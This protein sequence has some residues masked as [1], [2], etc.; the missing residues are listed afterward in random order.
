LGS[1]GRTELCTKTILDAQLLGIVTK[2]LSAAPTA[3][4]SKKRPVSK[5]NGLANK[6][7]AHLSTLVAQNPTIRPFFQDLQ[8]ATGP[9]YP[10][11]LPRS[12]TCDWTPSTPNLPIS[13]SQPPPL[14]NQNTRSPS[15]TTIT[16]PQP[17][18]HPSTTYRLTKHPDQQAS[19]A[20]RHNQPNPGHLLPLHN[21][22]KTSSIL[23]SLLI[24]RTTITASF[25]L[26][27]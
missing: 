4:Y 7:I 9:H 12:T 24:A 23:T 27:S 1:L 13:Q 21:T 2:G 26:Q 20:P 8:H 5:T 22:R 3:R 15:P 18:P 11:F 17:Q 16:I 10:S 19:T 25:S 6:R 14:R